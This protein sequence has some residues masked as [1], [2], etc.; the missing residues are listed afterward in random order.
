MLVHV[1][2]APLALADHEYSKRAWVQFKDMAD[3]QRPNITF[4]HGSLSHVDCAAKT[5]TVVKHGTDATEPFTYDY[6][7]SATGYRRAWPVVPQSLAYKQYLA[8][9]MQ[10]IQ[11]CANAQRGGGVLVVGGG[12]VGVE[13]AAELKLTMPNVDVTLAHSRDK[14]LSSEDLSDECKDVSLSLLKD[15]DVSVLMNH[16]LDTYEPVESQDGFPEHLA[17]FTNGSTIQVGVVIEAVSN[18][19]PATSYLPAPALDSQGKVKIR[20]K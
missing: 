2:G 9:T 19:V 1:V 16:R 20:P 14:L 6:F 4:M 3:L 12:A 8:E 15:A 10:H 11:A 7:C 18:S 17:K 5:A 13:M